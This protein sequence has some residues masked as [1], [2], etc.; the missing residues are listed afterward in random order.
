M[1]FKV[2]LIL[3]GAAAIAGCRANG[4]SDSYTGILEGTSIQVPALTAGRIVR[5]F[6]ETG[7]LVQR[8]DT[9]AVIDT[10]ELHLQWQQLLAKR[11][12][13]ESNREA[14]QTALRQAQSD[15]AYLQKKFDRLKRLYE[16][17]TTPKQS[18]DDL[19]QQLQRAKTALANARNKLRTLDALQAQLDAQI[20]LVRKKI[21]DSTIVSPHAGTVTTLYYETGEAVPPMAPVAELIDT[22]ELTVKIYV[23]EAV[24]PHVRVGQKATLRVDGLDRELK[25]QVTWI[26]PKSEFTPK[27]ILTPET[28]S[29][30]VYAVKVTVRNPEGIL[31]HGMP[32]EV[33][34]E[35][36]T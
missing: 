29:T 27:S 21:N 10:T 25:G 11:E 6:V 26:S 7:S 28:R 8:G 9:L 18:L 14:A 33:V 30:L 1:Q 34:L 4:S 5:S 17:E 36:R 20:A 15:V 23:A 19:S 13:L 35:Q 3:A 12:E 24:L 32:V 16:S 31:K 22:Q 2:W